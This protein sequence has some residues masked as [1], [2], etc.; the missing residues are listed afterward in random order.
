MF[1]VL[2]HEVSPNYLLRKTLVNKQLE[3]KVQQLEETCSC[4]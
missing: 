1:A 4:L 2:Q 3:S